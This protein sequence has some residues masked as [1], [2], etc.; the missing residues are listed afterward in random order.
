MLSLY[1]S[2]CDLPTQVVSLSLTVTVMLYQGKNHNDSMREAQC[3]AIYEIGKKLWKKKT[4][5]VETCISN[6]IKPVMDTATNQ[7]STVVSATS[8]MVVSDLELN[9]LTSAGSI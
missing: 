9:K 4:E 1:M 7:E 8:D 2:F 6:Y 3:H 5:E